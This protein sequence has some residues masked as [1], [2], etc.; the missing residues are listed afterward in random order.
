MLKL[1]KNLTVKQFSEASTKTFSGK[2]DVPK[3]QIDGSTFTS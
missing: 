2:K 1:T 3:I